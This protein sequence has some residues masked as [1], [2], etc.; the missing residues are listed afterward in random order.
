MKGRIGKYKDKIVVWGDPNLTA[1]NEINIDSLGGGGGQSSIPVEYYKVVAPEGENLDAIRNEL[2][3]SIASIE[4]S[5]NVSSLHI[6]VKGT[7]S[8][9]ARR[10]FTGLPLLAVISLDNTS[11]HAYSIRALQT[12]TKV[13]N[14]DGTIREIPSFNNIFDAFDSIMPSISSQLK[15][16]LVPITAEEFYN[17]DDME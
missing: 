3:S 1:K 4:D 16:I 13:V 5:L 10:L 9:N 11:I 17:L 8:M 12:I 2:F 7:S 15:Q 6:L 14:I